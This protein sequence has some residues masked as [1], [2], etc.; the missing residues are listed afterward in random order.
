MTNCLR[1]LLTAAVLLGTAPAAWSGDVRIGFIDPTGPPEFWDLVDATMKAAAAELDIDLDIRRTGRSREKAIEFARQFISESPR[2]DYL[3][4]TND[5]DAGAEIVKLADAAQLKLILL[6][7]DLTM[8]NWPEYG[9]PRTKYKSWL[10]SIVPDH[11]GAGYGIGSAILTEAARL[12]TNRP[13]KVL[14]VTGDAVT[15]AGLD[16]VRG[17]KRS[18]EVMT[19]LLGAGQVDL[20]DVRYLDWTAK[21]AEASVRDF[22]AKGPRIDALWAANDPMALGSLVALHENGYTPGRDVLVGGLNWSQDAVDKVLNGEM[23]VTHGGHFLLGAWAMVVLRDHHDGRDFAEEDVRLQTPMGAIDLPVARRF[24]KIGSVDW[25][26][27]DF[28]RFSK[29]RNPAVKRYEFTPDAVLA[30]LRSPH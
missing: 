14:A 15:P 28:T 17:L 11:E 5:V 9:E 6:N 4:A 27:V 13:L 22:A 30:Q 19:K 20:V 3:I 8:Q 29:T 24:P 2:V 1:A 18:I 23:V 16:R 26:Q 10:G 25:S 12:K 21:T 7:N